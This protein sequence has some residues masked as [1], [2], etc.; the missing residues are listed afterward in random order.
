MNSD[1][2]S[3]RL[4]TA[5][6]PTL[7]KSKFL[8]TSYTASII[9]SHFVLED[10]WKICTGFILEDSHSTRLKRILLCETARH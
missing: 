5:A 4:G 6:V 3:L 1:M 10:N 9:G 2:P 7:H 8:F